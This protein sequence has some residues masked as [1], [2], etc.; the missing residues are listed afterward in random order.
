M[1]SNGLQFYCTNFLLLP[2]SPACVDPVAYK[3]IRLGCEKVFDQ[4]TFGM[5][6]RDVEISRRFCGKKLLK[7]AALPYVRIIVG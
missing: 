3:V 5:A 4:D 6:R 2:A 7:R 1:L